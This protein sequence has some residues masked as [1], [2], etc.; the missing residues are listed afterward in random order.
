VLAA[1]ISNQSVVVVMV[2]RSHLGSHR[3]RN[4]TLAV[5][6]AISPE[7]ALHPKILRIGRSATPVGDRVIWP[8]IA[9]RRKTSGIVI[10]ADIMADT[11]AGPEEIPR[12]TPS[13]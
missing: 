2:D 1:D 7:I 9:R 12:R 10:E 5:G 3:G 11:G 4:A 13:M 6:L 8:R